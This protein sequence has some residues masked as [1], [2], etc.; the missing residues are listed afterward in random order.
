M[1][2]KRSVSERQKH[3]EAMLKE[4]LSRPGVAEYMKVYQ[5]WQRCDRGLDSYREA[6]KNLRKTTT[7]NHFNTSDMLG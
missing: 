4:A 6:V 5:N 2:A 3:H 7:T 1:T